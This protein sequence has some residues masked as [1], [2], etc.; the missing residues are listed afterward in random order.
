MKEKIHLFYTNDLHSQFEHWPRVATYLKEE[1]NK[2]QTENKSCWI[3]DIGDHIDRVNLIAEAFM[4]KANVTLMNE[5]EYDIATIGNNEGITM[6]HEDLYALY[7]DA[8]FQVVCTNLQSRRHHNPDW[9]HSSII[10]TS[11]H[12][13]NIG[14]LGLTAPFN[15]FYNL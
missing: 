5:L 3:V 7:D 9:L 12:G 4:G 1:K 11:K 8:H 2:K 10:K 15:A 6:A 14:I 13:V